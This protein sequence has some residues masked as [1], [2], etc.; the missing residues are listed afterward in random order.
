MA[1]DGHYLDWNQK[2]IKGIVDFYG[3]KFMYYKKVL[4][5]GCGYADISGVLHR[6]GADI[7]AVDARQ[8]HLKIVS[9]KFSGIKTVQADLDRGWPFQ[10]K[11]FDLVLDLGIVCHLSNFESH[12]KSVCAS[13]THLVLETAVCD[14]SDPYKVIQVEENKGSYDLSANGL[15]CRPSAAAIE[16]ILTECGMNFKRVDSSSYNAAGY[17][18]DWQ[19][20]DNDNTDIHNRRMWFAVKKTSPIQFAKPTMDEQIPNVQGPIPSIPL[21]N[22]P[23]TPQKSSPTPPYKSPPQILLPQ[24][25]NKR[26][27]FTAQQNY[28]TNK[29]PKV[30]LFYNYYEDKNPIRKQ[31]IDLCLQNNINNQAFDLIVL[32]S[33]DKPTFDFFFQKINQLAEPNDISIIC[34]SDVFFDNSIS[35]ASR[36]GDQEVYALSRW[37]WH[38]LSAPT[39]YDKT[40]S[41]D[42]WILKGKIENVNGNFKVG[43]PNSDARIA[44]E[45]QQ[46]GYSIRNASKTIKAFH[47]NDSNTVDFSNDDLVSGPYLSLPIV[48]L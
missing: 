26:Q 25:V 30:R 21:A 31:E 22:L 27:V 13:T 16:R 39:L 43:S 19:S 37:D 40:N 34:N 9:K 42:A 12:L 44:F 48:N 8:E 32:D 1:F 20:R 24:P 46:A 28:N 11:M 29:K 45:F 18:Y 4:D 6:L 7:T 3:Y 33:S 35:F 47:F 15:G 41:Q 14:S 17:V 36:V 2:R 38:R 23:I 10:G 5:L